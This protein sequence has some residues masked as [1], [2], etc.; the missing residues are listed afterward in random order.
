MIPAS[1]F[2]DIFTAAASRLIGK[3]PPRVAVAV[4][5]GADS[6][7]LTL[8][9]QK[10][11]S[12][13]GGALIA[14][15]VDHGLRALSV[16][17]AQRVAAQMKEQ[18]IAHH[19][20]RWDGDKPATRIQERARQARYDLLLQACRD[21][22][23][24]YLATAHHAQDQMETFWMRLAHGSGLDGLCAMAP[25]RDIDGI[26]HIRPLL[27]FEKQ[28]LRAYCAAQKMDW[29]EDPSNANDAF[30][31]PR[32]RGFEDLLA[33]EGLTPQ[34]LSLTLG[35][36]QQ[37]KEALD[38][39]ADRAEKET[40]IAHDAGYMTLAPGAYAG[41]PADIRLRVLQGVLK[42]FDPAGYAVPHAQ[43][44]QLDQKIVTENDAFSG[45]TLSGVDIFGHDGAVVFAREYAAVSPPQLCGDGDIWDRRW[46]VS[47]ATSATL[48]ALG[49]DGLQF[50]KNNY[51]HDN[52][53]M[54]H[55]ASL[56]YKVRLT[57]PCF[58]AADNIISL[59]GLGWGAKEYACRPLKP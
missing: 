40:V 51:G 28:D 20:L 47:A 9:L 58:A 1:D 41:F 30:L 52:N 53:L 48:R 21:H 13:R 15:T 50:L 12:A 54:N 29:V 32:L 10:F 56:P 26:T 25:A 27:S 2:D 31:R 33:Q 42:R 16:Q 5:G 49:E 45:Q 4:S 19:I 39:I 35:K 59:P 55:M 8:L 22:A 43:V 57:L 23:L 44:E 24:D 14:F 37:A 11:V 36:L 17:E 18:G 46:R 7:A 6:L 3:S 38:W 34:R